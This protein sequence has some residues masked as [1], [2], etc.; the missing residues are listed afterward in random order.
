M[1]FIIDKKL[2][3]KYNTDVSVYVYVKLLYKGTMEL[4]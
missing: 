2:I 1:Y 3:H 4:L